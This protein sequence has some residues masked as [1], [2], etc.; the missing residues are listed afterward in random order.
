MTPRPRKTPFR[1]LP[2][3]LYARKIGQVLYYQYRDPITHKFLALGTNKDEAI[4]DAHALNADA[5]AT[6]RATRLAYAK[7]ETGP[8]FA[9]WIVRYTDIVN[10]ERQPRPNTIRTRDNALKRAVLHLGTVPIDQVTVLQVAEILSALTDD[11]KDRMALLVRS[12]LMDVFRVAKSEGLVTSN[13]AADTRPPRATVKRERLTLDTFLAI[14]AVAEHEEAWI[15]N[16]M[17]LAL[18]TGQRRESIV[19]MEFAHYREGHLHIAQ[20]KTGALVRID[21][22]I[23]LHAVSMTIAD[24]IARC[25][26]NVVSRWMLHHSTRRRGATP[27]QPVHIDSIS[28]KFALC[29]DRTGLPWGPHPPTYHEIRSL[30]ARLYKAEGRD[31]QTL[32]GHK[33]AAMT[34]VYTDARGAEWVT[35]GL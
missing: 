23:G 24:V 19:A 34:A 20:G 32:L 4:L 16:S 6:K 12:T 21:A 11:G 14:A 31:P 9:D 25:R 22:R 2:P 18:L 27:G 1:D 17:W 33:N 10:R 28:K 26:D 3:N 30:S 29:R 5:F 35:V 15:A 8:T 7:K 13:P